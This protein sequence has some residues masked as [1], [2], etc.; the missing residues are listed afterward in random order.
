MEDVIVYALPLFGVL[1]GVEFVYG[2]LRGRNN[3]GFSD[4]LSSLS[5]GL[6][7][8]VVAVCTQVVQVG[9]Y[10]MAYP[11]I[12]LAPDAAIWQRSR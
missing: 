11:F 5:Q 12:A 7:S 9:L 2:L 3:Y 10:A 6:L 4:T 1:M 8:Q